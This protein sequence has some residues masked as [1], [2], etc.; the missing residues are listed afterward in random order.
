MKT[1]PSFSTS[2]KFTALPALLLSLALAAATAAP[3]A[4]QS[5]IDISPLV[6]ADNATLTL[7]AS[8][9]YTPGDT[10]NL[11]GP[12]TTGTIDLG[13]SAANLAGVFA[14]GGQSFSLLGAGITTTT[15]TL[16][17][18]R[19]NTFAATP[20]TGVLDL[21]HLA[22]NLF[23]G[24][25]ALNSGALRISTTAQLGAPL[26]K[27]KFA[28]T[29]TLIAA[30]SMTFDGASGTTQ[31]LDITGT[32]T[33]IAAPGAT[34]AIKNSYE[35][36]A[37]NNQNFGGGAI[38]VLNSTLILSGTLNGA[39]GAFLFESN[40]SSNRGAG[41]HITGA[42]AVAYIDS[43]TFRYNKGPSVAVNG[44][45]LYVSNGG[46]AF[47]NNSSFIENTAFGS[48]A[49]PGNGSGAALGLQAGAAT[50]IGNNLL[51]Q[52]NTA[53]A[54]GAV[55]VAGPVYGLFLTSATFT[56]NVA[57][58]T[59]G[60]G[61][62]GTSNNGVIIDLSQILF[63]SNTATIGVG[64]AM[65]LINSNASTYSVA[66]STFI[67]NYAANGGGAISIGTGSHNTTL[68]DVS[69]LNNKSTTTGGAINIAGNA[70]TLNLN[71][72]TGHTSLLAGN[73]A[74]G[75]TGTANSINFAANTALT[76]TASTAP[77][78]TL[79]MLDPMTAASGATLTIT[80]NGAGSWNLAG[81]NTLASTSTFTVATGTLHLYRANEIPASPYAIATGNLNITGPTG[82][83][84]LKTNAT[85]H[86]AGGGGVATGNTITAP[87]ITLEPNSILA[88][89]LLGATTTTPSILTLNAATLTSAWNQ[90]ISL[91]NLSTLTPAP[92]DTYNLITLAG[93]PAASLFTD[94]SNL[95]L[96]VPAT[97][98]YTLHIANSGSTLQLLY[99]L[100][101]ATNNILTWTGS[102]AGTSPLWRA[103]GNW[104]LTADNT[105]GTTF[106]KGDIV[107]FTDTPAPATTT[108]NIDTAPVTTVA[109]YVSG[110]ANYTITGTNAII[111]DP[112]S[113]VFT[114]TAAATGQLVLGAKARGDAT[115]DPAAAYTGT[116]TLNNTTNTFTN[117]IDIR[118]GALVGNAA[119]LGVGPTGTVAIAP[120]AT[121]TFNQAANATYS[122]PIAGA[123]AL[124]KTNTATLTLA[125]NSAAFT[126][127]TTIAAGALLLTTPAALGGNIN[128]ATG[129]TL[130]G[131]GTAGAVTLG[132][133]ATLQVGSGTSALQTF[134]L[135]ALSLS[136]GSFL[137]YTNPT[138]TLL[139]AGALSQT[140]TST[141]NFTTLNIGTY[142]LINAAAGLAS[143]NPTLL[144]I[145][146]GGN[147]LTPVTD[148]TLAINGGLLQLTLAT[149]PLAANN[150]LTWTNATGNSTWL[151]S[152]NWFVASATATK[153]FVQADIVNL[154]GSGAT[155][156]PI[157]LAATAT[158]AG[159]YVSGTASYALAGPGALVTTASA[160]VLAGTG[161]ATGKLVLGKTAPD[162]SAAANTAFTGTLDLTGLAGPNNFTAGIEI[163]SGAL[164]V[165]NNANL[166]IPTLDRLNITGIG[167]ATL[168]V[169]GL[170]AYNDNYAG[171][172]RLIL[173]PNT[174]LTII[175][176]T[177]AIFAINRSTDTATFA[178]GGTGGGAITV[179]A[180]ATLPLASA[181]GSFLFDSNTT[182][183]GRAGAINLAGA[184]SV[185]TVDSAVFI[186]NSQGATGQTNG[187]AVAIAA[188]TGTFS[189]SNSVFVN[190]KTSPLLTGAGG[191]IANQGGALYINN[192]LFDSNTAANGGAI[193]DVSTAANGLV[194]N[195][196]TFINNVAT[197]ANGGGAIYVSTTAIVNI[198][199]TL[200]QGNTSASLGG[201]YAGLYASSPQT[202]LTK[203]TLTDVSFINNRA[204]TLG[205]A[206]YIAGNNS[207][208]TWN[209][210]PG[211]TSLV[212]GNI[213]NGAPSGL[214]VVNNY[215]INVTINVGEGGLL[216]MRDPIF[217]YLANTSA[218]VLF[219]TGPGT[220]NLAG[221]G[222]SRPANASPSGA[223]ITYTINEGTLHL[224]RA[225][226][227]SYNGVPVAAGGL[228]N[229]DTISGAPRG[230][231]NFVLKDPATLSAGGGNFINLNTINLGTNATLALDLTAATTAGAGATGYAVLTLT[232][233]GV[234]S[235]AV[236]TPNGWTQ[237]LALQGLDTL[238]ANP[239]DTYNLISLK[240]PVATA[241]ASLFTSPNTFTLLNPLLDG[242]TLQLSPDATTL[243]LVYSGILGGNSVLTWAATATAGSWT[244]YNTW[245]TAATATSFH[246]GD[247]VNLA[248]TPAAIASATINVARVG[249]V[250][251]A[252]MSV[253]GSANY[254]ITGNPLT[255]TATGASDLAGAPA[256]TGQLVLGAKASANASAITPLDYTG[257]LTLANTAGG[258][259]AA[260]NFAGGIIIHTGA[261]V[262][263]AASLATG[264]AGITDNGTLIFDQPADA[265]YASPITGTGALVKTNTAALTLAATAAAFTGNTEVAAGEL[266][267]ANTTLGS[268]T[269]HI[270]PAATLG[271]SGTIAGSVDADPAAAI[272]IG[273]GAA[274]GQT[275]AIAGNLA[276]GNAAILNYAALG[277]KLLVAG[278]LAQTGTTIINLASFQS[279]TF[280][281]GN[282]A[283]LSPN[284]NLTIDGVQQ[285]PDARQNA[286]LAT[287]GNDLLLIGA[288]DI[289]RILYWTGT[290]NNTWALTKSDWTDTVANP[291]GTTTVFGNGD[292]V[293]FTD[294]Q[295]VPVATT[296]I[297][298][299]DAGVIASD[300]YVNGTTSYLFTGGP[301]AT[302]AASVFS[303]S[304]LNAGATTGKLYKTNTGTLTLANNDNHFLG[305][306]ELTAGVLAIGGT[307]SAGGLS[308]LAAAATLQM[309]GG[310]LN[311][312]NLQIAA[313]STLAGTGIIAGAATLN[314][315]VNAP[316][317]AGDT[318]A[319]AGALAGPGGIL[320]TGDGELRFSGTGPFLNAGATQATE[321]T[322]RFAG[323]S[324]YTTGGVVTLKG[325]AAISNSGSTI[326]LPSSTFTVSGQ[327][328]VY[329]GGT[330][331]TVGLT[332]NT[333]ISITTGTFSIPGVAYTAYQP[334]VIP[335]C[336]V[337]IAGSPTV[338]PSA[339]Y[340]APGFTFAIPAISIYSNI[341]VSTTSVPYNF[342]AITIPGYSLAALVT[343]NVLID[344]G[345]VAFGSTPATVAEA[346]ASDWA[347]VRLIQGDAA[348]T[349]VITGIND[350]IHI[351]N[352]GTFAPA[353]TGGL[354]VAVNAG[355]GTA[356]LGNT[357]NDFTGIVRI[358]GGVLQL[359][360]PAQFGNMTAGIGNKVVLNGGNLE[361][362]TPIS[363]TKNI[364]L[365]AQ[366]GTVIVDDGVSTSWAAINRPVGVTAAA[367]TA[368]FTKAGS[369]T[370]TL[371][372]AF[373]PLG[374]NVDAGRFIAQSGQ[375]SLPATGTVAVAP[376]AVIELAATAATQSPVIGYINNQ[377]F[378]VLTTGTNLT[379]AFTG[380]GTLAVTNGKYILAAAKSDIAA[381]NVTGAT[382][383][384][385]I[386]NNYSPN[387][388]FCPDSAIT[389]DKGSLI[390]GAANQTLGDVTLDNNATL[391]FLM[392]TS[393]IASGSTG[394]QAQAFK[395]ATLKT[396][397]NAGTGPA[398]LY[399]N[400]NLALGRADRLVITGAPVSG[401]FN[402][403]VTNY[404]A[405]SNQPRATLELLHSPS[406]GAPA[407]DNFILLTPTIGGPGDLFIYTVTA[408]TTPDATT[409]Q[410]G[411]TGALSNSAQFIKSM[412]S[413]LP[414]SWFAELDSLTQRLGEL[415]FE[416]RNSELG[417]RNSGGGAAAWLRGYGEKLN[418]NA[419]LTGSPFG[420]TH[421]AGEAGVDWKSTSSPDGDA[422]ALYLGAFAGYGNSQRDYS[423]DGDARSDSAFAGVYA[424][425]TTPGGWY[426]DAIAKFNNF[427]NRFNAA[428]P[429]GET[430]AA[431]YH[432]WAMGA[433]L[434]TGLSIDI[435]GG[436]YLEPQ[437]QVALT[438]IAATAYATD[439]GIAVSQSPGSATRA[440]AGLRLGRDFETDHYGRFSIYLKFHYGHQWMNNGQVIAAPASGGDL[441][442]FTPAL[443]GETVDGGG[444]V[445]WLFT[446]NTQLYIDYEAA[447]SH[448]YVKP[449][450]VNFGIRHGW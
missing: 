354:H 373:Q 31:R 224:Y 334:A 95:N 97:S 202:Y 266:L 6:P 380:G 25:V 169:A 170:L 310:V 76:L 130:G 235:S 324:G 61:A 20:F 119:S 203:T 343:Q 291:T 179:G 419:N 58:A 151:A 250:T 59:G 121:L 308:T 128:V 444:G 87:A 353:L 268:A 183:G 230:V 246:T 359:T 405:L 437:A 388:S 337:T 282:L 341:D 439:S 102:A 26:S 247:I 276:L 221:T 333:D 149:M 131:T 199:N 239:G 412:A 45:G 166:G 231:A 386:G 272:Q 144:G 118:A 185:A 167:A 67:N 13:A 213:A 8:I 73:T 139:V 82:A 289:S 212:A 175:S 339:T 367:Y 395:T 415:H 101:I 217:F 126:G 56:G 441:A 197:G 115:I 445:A 91:L 387:V 330:Y 400:T 112:A 372:G 177:N 208:L 300:M 344:G 190:N 426:L 270:A 195:S 428:A 363:T 117:G 287:S 158:L 277:D 389:I 280:N 432:N 293:Y 220:W 424:T 65:N 366:T 146:Y 194:I 365:R 245:T 253:S 323:A 5:T 145:N 335:S 325:D 351:N 391:A 260:N 290:T 236:F 10:W 242:F 136:D 254:T 418:F 63:Q 11:A 104:V 317:A 46:T 15:G 150:V 52:S 214:Y 232:A 309:T 264:P 30:S 135:S 302:D 181:G 338:I 155:A 48:Q 360:N 435:G 307:T 295:I 124:N 288:G 98:G 433:S 346:A 449:W 362:S 41:I 173:A 140:G 450:G 350:I 326:I 210:S 163:N 81:D 171:N 377:P 407:T 420:E 191:A 422:T 357:A 186:N 223:S 89:D 141:F 430:T 111:T 356:V 409:I 258:A 188:A 3:L 64:G 55:I 154:S 71:V 269:T 66:S 408:T 421:Y 257:T 369:G 79:D 416:T 69:F 285:Y 248:D 316:I 182:N 227:T 138:N 96:L 255:A 403:S 164:R 438:T 226:E 234:G 162:T 364:E 105:T 434:E 328:F 19:N 129:A 442:Q 192:T 49:Y 2:A 233:T 40:T 178:T 381:V 103:P 134:N 23:G 132:S 392:N 342:G 120:G 33:L 9:P 142:T 4:A 216:D 22:A 198:A 147:L 53:S 206:L 174:N 313:D 51:F 93:V 106:A 92:N 294:P 447:Q 275:L 209:V 94:I 252:A 35:G 370:F 348:A 315:L 72:T 27:L 21:T 228:F 238:A 74:G 265:A 397:A 431:R 322:V 443:K 374:L 109:M 305:G 371:T 37:A 281:L 399:L 28:G 43:A 390:F 168:L 99:S 29:G 314:G 201:A 249:G 401:T 34:F 345:T 114:T 298:I 261:L 427:K 84:I 413:A 406:T 243:Q 85:L 57:I 306:I 299:A 187:G 159:M 297:T 62:I 283:A 184:N 116:L 383:A 17:L 204:G 229:T 161:V 240:G 271:G 312:S 80:K 347:G 382:T 352:S 237:N 394:T 262:G 125:A 54:A 340:T 332:I 321:G 410:I 376:G 86:A 440:R 336:T 100:N 36:V 133:A 393:T 303:G 24:G 251:L 189:V 284:T 279:G 165:S 137:N 273:L 241:Q 402:V 68:T 205:G 211:Q 78:A 219:K 225:G 263:N 107:N 222:S 318:L 368:I 429:N 108:I 331:A 60:G 278:T 448:Y 39:G 311:A 215:N 44:A 320:K 16:V 274:P 244:G 218:D 358:D 156:T 75:A 193:I 385:V 446:K 355:S 196:S 152:A 50:V 176:Q 286:T 379:T 122:T 77:G 207:T 180:G 384:I 127:T 404:G 361:I 18:G 301:L 396:L 319:L 436:L 7:G 143:L 292:R 123:G 398:N 411:T 42:T 14:Y 47:I 113:G 378:T 153:A 148:Y 38:H 172:N 329:P 267:L 423:A 200:F 259:G 375:T 32:A 157:T 304:I 296:T 349:S 110:T 70:N 90:T 12:Y 256:A 425:I 327:T 88:L 1:T 417:T 160:G 414:S 83:F